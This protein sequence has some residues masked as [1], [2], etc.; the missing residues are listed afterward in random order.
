MLF[1]V[2]GAKS[3]DG[4]PAMDPAGFHDLP[5]PHLG[6]GSN[7]DSSLIDLF[8]ASGVDTPEQ[9]GKGIPPK[10]IADER[11][12]SL[13]PDDDLR[14]RAVKYAK[15]AASDKF[16]KQNETAIRNSFYDEVHCGCSG[17]ESSMLRIITLSPSN[18]R[19]GEVQ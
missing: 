14:A 16:A 5:S 7:G 6:Y 17:I 8:K 2:P 19:S 12:L 18:A 15:M 11:K 13:P 10:A 9:R 3:S 4:L 1:F